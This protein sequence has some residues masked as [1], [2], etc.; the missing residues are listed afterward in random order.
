[1]ANHGN[2]NSSG[3]LK[4]RSTKT[5]YAWFPS[6]LYEPVSDRDGNET[7]FAARLGGHATSLYTYLC[8][9]ADRETQIATVGRDKIEERTGLSRGGVV[10]LRARLEAHGLVARQG[11]GAGGRGRANDYLLLD[12]AHWCIDGQERQVKGSQK[13]SQN[14]QF[15][16]QSSPQRGH[17]TGH[18]RG[19]ET[20]HEMTVC[21]TSSISSLEDSRK[22]NQQHNAQST[23]NAPADVVDVD[24]STPST[25]IS[26]TTILP[27]AAATST[28]PPFGIASLTARL[29]AQRI[30]EPYASQFAGEWPEGG[31]SRDDLMCA[32][33]RHGL[34]RRARETSP[35]ALVT[36]D[37]EAVRWQLVLWP[38]CP[39]FTNYDGNK[40]AVLV[41]RIQVDDAP[42]PGFIDRLRARIARE[43]AVRRQQAEVLRRQE[44]TAALD[45]AFASLDEMARQAVEGEAR[46]RLGGAAEFDKQGF[47]LRAK[48]RQVM[49][50]LAAGA[51]PCSSGQMEQEQP[52][53]AISVVDVVKSAPEP[54][55]DHPR[56]QAAR[57]LATELRDDVITED[58]LADRC[59]EKS[60]NF[61]DEEV[62]VVVA[63][64]RARARARAA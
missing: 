39:E 14:D 5:R 21:S 15:N 33:E 47:G 26:S 1:M 24:R 2:D 46:R 20:G 6:L 48:I 28:P 37:A 17:E 60:P 32:L 52:A 42:P 19:H 25:T 53:G 3:S 18:K 8:N 51:W 59:R 63:E 62:A 34:N 22:L 27:A 49:S 58:V 11:S 29:V 35:H 31:M 55:P 12:V 9:C 43:E 30:P 57:V 16:D 41:R 54:P 36:A 4:P 23:R 40:A 50:D 38:Y 10:K 44:D 45:A 64:A 13:G 61:S 7:T 56:R